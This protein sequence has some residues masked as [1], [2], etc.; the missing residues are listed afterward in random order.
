M[1]IHHIVKSV[2]GHPSSSIDGG[3]TAERGLASSGTV[4]SNIGRDTELFRNDK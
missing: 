2:T 3:K 1:H 4:R